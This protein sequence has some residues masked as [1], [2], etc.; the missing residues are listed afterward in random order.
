MCMFVSLSQ[1]ILDHAAT[2]ESWEVCEEGRREGGG[3][4]GRS[5]GRRQE[6][7][8]EGSQEGERGGTRL[9]RNPA[10]ISTRPQKLGYNSEFGKSLRKFPKHARSRGKFAK[11]RSP[12]SEYAI[13]F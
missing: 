5:Q 12:L 13:L 10:T 11:F 4:R 1:D 9:T 2:K 8:R 3:K 7:T 6:V